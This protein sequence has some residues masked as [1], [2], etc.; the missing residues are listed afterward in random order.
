MVL[1]DA[2]WYCIAI[3]V[4]SMVIVDNKVNLFESMALLSGYVLYIAYIFYG[5]NLNLDLHQVYSKVLEW[6]GEEPTK[7]EQQDVENHDDDASQQPTDMMKTREA[8]DLENYTD[9]RAY[10]SILYDVP[11]RVHEKCWFVLSWPIHAICKIS[12]PDC[13][14][15]IFHHVFGLVASFVASIC[16]IGVLSHYTTVIVT[17]IGCQA[18][19]DFPIMGLTILAAGTSIPDALA[20]ISGT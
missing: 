16:W 5:P 18:H 8:Q 15:P 4:L 13:R 10:F 20:S 2:V 7:D 14:F 3:F 12:I 6:Q 9:D 11:E 1:R 17:E 19:I